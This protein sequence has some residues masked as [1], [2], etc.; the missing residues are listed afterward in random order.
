MP[1]EVQSQ[2]YVMSVMPSYNK[3]DVYCTIKGTMGTRQH[4]ENSR[5]SKL[6]KNDL[7]TLLIDQI[8]H[9]AVIAKLRTG[10]QV[11]VKGIVDF[12]RDNFHPIYVTEI[13]TEE[14]H[15]ELKKL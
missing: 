7:A 4:L 5:D 13:K 8:K 15:S 10:C 3:N 11:E 1:Y 12:E 2:F 9:G 14:R 6:G